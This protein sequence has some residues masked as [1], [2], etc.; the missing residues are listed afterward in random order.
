M[1]QRAKYIAS[2]YATDLVGEKE[3]VVLLIYLKLSLD[4]LST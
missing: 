3:N 2:K 4:L 1:N